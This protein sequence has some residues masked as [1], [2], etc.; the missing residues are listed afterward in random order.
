MEP[1]LTFN[2]MIEMDMEEGE[3]CELLLSGLPGATRE[4]GYIR[5]GYNLLNLSCNPRADKIKALSAENGWLYYRFDLSVFPVGDAELGMQKVLAEQIQEVLRSVK[6][7][8][9]LVAEF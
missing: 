4:R 3:L 2:V 8:F 6:G 1:D 9:E 7:S 5:S